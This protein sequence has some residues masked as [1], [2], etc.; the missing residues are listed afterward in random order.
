LNREIQDEMEAMVD[1]A[2]HAEDLN[3]WMK[4]FIAAR[5]E[6]DSIWSE[7]T[8]S[9]HGMLGGRSP[10][11]IKAAAL[12][13]LVMLT[14]DIVD[15][16]QDRD[17]GHRIWMTCP[18]AYTLNAV[19]AFLM[20]FMG[21]AGQLQWQT[22]RTMTPF[23]PE[24]SQWVLSAVN[25]QQKDLNPHAHIAD[26]ADYFKMVQLKS[27]SLIQLAC[28]L[29]YS[30]AESS[31]AGLTG[32][33][34]ELAA[35]LGVVAQIENDVRNLEQLGP[36]NDILQ[37]KRTLPILYM[38][39]QEQDG[40]PELAQYYD[41]RLG[42]EDFIRQHKQACLQAIADSGC[43]EYAKIIQALYYDKAEQLF[44]SMPGPPYWKERFRRVTLDRYAAASLRN[45][46]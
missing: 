13:E 5:A 32:Q 16:L 42:A 31:S 24:I 4:S 8:E 15:D 29:G 20:M 21:E 40:F 30:L 2:I 41:G 17:K 3:G 25:G 43:L 34:D 26:E 36:G 6:G 14:L 38:L 22:G 7:L 12:T 18:E 23:L 28:Y 19:L 9:T 44:E 1:R 35:C 27:G 46:G 11:I 33:I 39:S 10:H 45:N 37:K